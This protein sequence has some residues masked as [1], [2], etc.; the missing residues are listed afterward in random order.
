LLVCLVPVGV[1]L[2]TADRLAMHFPGIGS[3][4]YT[5]LRSL[6]ILGATVAVVY[7]AGHPAGF[8]AGLAWAVPVFVLANLVG[9]VLLIRAGRRWHNSNYK[10]RALSAA[11]AAEELLVVAG[12][13]AEDQRAW[14]TAARSSALVHELQR[15]ALRISRDHRRLA[16]GEGW[17]PIGRA[18]RSLIRSR[19]DRLQQAVLEYRRRLTDVTSQAEYD[20]LVDQARHDLVALAT[21]EWDVLPSRPSTR[22]TAATVA[23]AFST[24]A[25]G[26]AAGIATNAASEHLPSVMNQPKVAWP[27]IIVCTVLGGILCLRVEPHSAGG[28]NSPASVALI[29]RR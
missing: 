14:R 13:L 9:D 23:A 18:D 10:R 11:V 19:G 22:A 15:Y 8:V 26:A 29:C 25:L 6:Q 17:G 1:L 5:A 3:A 21:N 20:D 4:A 24:A 7:A 28:K 16:S 12:K 27:A 2:K